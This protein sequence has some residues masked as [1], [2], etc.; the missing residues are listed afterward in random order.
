VTGTFQTETGDYRFLEGT[1]QGDKLYL[2]VFDGAHAF[3]F[4][5]R[6][7]ATGDQLVGY[8]RSG[9]HYRTIWE[10]KRDA[11]AKLPDP[12]SL[13]KVVGPDKRLNFTFPNTDGEL[14]SL[15]DS[16]FTGKVKLVQ[17]MGTWCPNCLD[18]TRFLLRYLSENAHPDLQVLAIGFERYRD[19]DKALAALR[20][21][22]KQLNIPY[23]VLWGGYYDKS[24]A[25]QSFP[26][27]S[28]I[29]AYPTLLFVDRNNEI[30]FVHTGFN[31]PATTEYAAFAQWFKTTIEAMIHSE[32]TQ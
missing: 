10:A 4:E 8:F 30:Q 14:I 31:G 24:E 16:A 5:A 29:L 18:E 9:T 1:I 20:R 6:I 21:Y 23:P 28:R 3:L 7:A 25:A 11:T 13:T 19:A 27:L 22:Q 15:A 32:N 2:S 12:N 26:M 17:I